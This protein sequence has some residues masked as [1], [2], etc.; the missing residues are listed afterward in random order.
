M[1]T[2]VELSGVSKPAIP[3]DHVVNNPISGSQQQ[4]PQPQADASYASNAILQRLKE[5]EL[6]NQEMQRNL[7]EKEEHIK[8]LEHEKKGLEEEKMELS[9]DRIKDMKNVYETSVDDWIE[10]LEGL[11][12]ELKER[13]K[14]G[15]GDLINKGEVKNH[16]WQV[17]CNASKTHRKQ[18]DKIEELVQACTSKDKTIE[19]LLKSRDDPSFSNA[20]SRVSGFKRSAHD[21]APPPAS[22]VDM[23]AK[24]VATPQAPVPA[25]SDASG[26]DAW[27]LFSDMLNRESKNIYY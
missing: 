27:D 5:I 10:T 1:A 16:T 8:S 7:Q 24:R 21:M 6:A 18:L 12:P 11:S 22:A 17:L 2:M 3:T 25:Q 20:Y 13:I 15:L 14:K 26:G 19:E 9:I 4:A 23:A